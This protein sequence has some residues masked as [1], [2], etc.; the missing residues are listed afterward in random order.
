MILIYEIGGI[1]GMS[2]IAN[3]KVFCGDCGKH[4][5][6]ELTKLTAGDAFCSSC[7]SFDIYP[8]TPEGAN[9]SCSIATE[10]END[11]EKWTD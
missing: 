1:K 8:D 3:M 10:Y 6:V 4:F 9:A 11:I 2:K 5:I 7:G